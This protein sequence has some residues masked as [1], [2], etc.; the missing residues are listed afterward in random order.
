MKAFL[1][2]LALAAPFAAAGEATASKGEAGFHARLYERYCQSL[3]E[4]PEAYVRFVKRMQP[5]HGYTYEEFA[6]AKPGAAVRADC[7]VSPERIAAVH[8]ELQGTGID[9]SRR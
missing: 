5:I 8:R 9:A 7:G 4:S 1:I 6:P 3:R 2:A